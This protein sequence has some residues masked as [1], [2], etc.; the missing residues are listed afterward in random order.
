MSALTLSALLLIAVSAVSTTAAAQDT[1]RCGNSYS[2]TPCPGAVMVDTEDPRTGAQKRQADQATQRDARVASEM[3][4]ARLQQEARDLA[5]SKP[6]PKA[7]NPASAPRNKS[8]Q[9]NKT[10]RKAPKA[11]IIKT[12][13]PKKIGKAPGPA[14]EKKDT[15]KP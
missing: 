13:E 5:A 1:F 7:S 2:Q 10:K 4:K 12:P 8:G 15:S 9:I 14:S 6:A 3:E 11:E